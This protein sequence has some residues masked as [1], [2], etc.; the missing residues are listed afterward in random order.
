MTRINPAVETRIARA[1]RNPLAEME[2]V[3]RA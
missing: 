3:A 1:R 2:A